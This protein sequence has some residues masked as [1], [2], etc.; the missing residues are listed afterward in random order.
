MSEAFVG[1]E[2]VSTCRTV[3]PAWP[4]H[5]RQA[6]QYTGTCDVRANVLVNA[7]GDASVEPGSAEEVMGILAGARGRP[8]LMPGGTSRFEVLGVDGQVVRLRNGQTPV[9]V[10]FRWFADAWRTLNRDGRLTRQTMPP[11][12][13]FRSGQIFAVLALHPSVSI[14]VPFPK[15]RLVFNRDG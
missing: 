11:E 14:D 8:I 1:G 9:T 15:T 7:T 4:S 13:K 10:P 2:S 5:H 3:V 6:R 12:A